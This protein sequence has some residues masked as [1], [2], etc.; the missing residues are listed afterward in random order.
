MPICTGG[1]SAC[2]RAC[3]G[4][5]AVLGPLEAWLLLRG[6]RTLFPR[7]HLACANA[8]TIAERAYFLEKGEVRFSGRTAD[9][10]ERSDVLRSVFLEG[11]AKAASLT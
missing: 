9:L 1:S 2:S 10:L 4:G 3:G 7:V 8:M 6:M 5:G 11:A